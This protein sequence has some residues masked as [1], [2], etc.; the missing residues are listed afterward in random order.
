MI[1]KKITFDSFI[2]AAM[3]VLIAVIILMILNRLSSVLLPFFVAWLI[4]YLIFP[5][6]QF[7]QYRCKMKYRVLAIV[8]AILAV[9]VVGTG[10]FV[11]II[12]PMFCQ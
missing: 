11:L 3:G 9:T 7:F 10:I 5:L 6:V 2:R 12:P 1:D 4:A 8:C